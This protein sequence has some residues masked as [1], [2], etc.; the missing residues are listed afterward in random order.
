MKNK[1]LS[2]VHAQLSIDPIYQNLLGRILEVYNVDRSRAK[3]IYDP[4]ERGFCEQQAIRERWSANIDITKF[5]VMPNH[6]DGIISIGDD[7][8]SNDVN[9][10]VGSNDVNGRGTMHRAPTIDTDNDDEPHNHIEKF[11]KP[12]SN[13]IPAIAVTTGVNLWWNA[14]QCLVWQQ[15]YYQTALKNAEEQRCALSRIWQMEGEHE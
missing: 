6:V 3:Q 5:I 15:N 7:P 13:M 2:I 8:G 10:F 14:P 9:G 11:G 12:T 4:V 1:E